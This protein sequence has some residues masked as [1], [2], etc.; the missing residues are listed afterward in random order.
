M[1][2]T[3]FF[4]LFLLF[5]A[6]LPAQPLTGIKTIK[7]GGGDYNS[8]TAAITA[9]NTNGV[10]TGGVVFQVDA[11]FNSTENPPAISATGTAANPVSFIKTGAGTNP[12]LLP[13][14]STATN[15]FG[16]KIDSADYITFDGIDVTISTGNA[17]EFGYWLNGASGNG[18][19]NNTIKN[20]TV[21]LN[22]TNTTTRGINSTVAT[23]VTSA[24]GANSQNKY[25]NVNIT[26]CYNGIILNGNTTFPDL[27]VEVAAVSGTATISS[28][29]GG[30]ILC[31]AVQLSSQSGYIVSG[32]V[33]EN[34]TSSA[35]SQLY[36][37]RQLG[38]PSN[39]SI[40][41]NTVRNISNS[42]SGSIYGISISGGGT[43]QNI[44]NNLIHNLTSTT[45]GAY[46]IEA[47]N[48]NA[49]HFIYENTIH[50]IATNATSNL[51]NAYGI[52]NSG[53]NV[54]L[55]VYRNHIYNIASNG[56]SA[57]LSA[58]LNVSGTNARIYN[59]FIFDIRN[60]S[61]TGT[62]SARGIAL[63]TGTSNFYV[64][65]NTVFLGYT[66]V[67]AANS[68][69]ALFTSAA[70]TADLRNNI[71]VNNVNV[72]A[73]TR[74]VA[75][76]R[77]STT[78]TLFT[79]T[80]DNNLYYAGAP[81]A[82][83][84]VFY[85]GTNADQTLLAY[86]NRM[87]NREWHSV[88][89]LPPFISTT[90]GSHNLHLNTATATQCEQGGRTITTPFA[91]D[92]DFDGNARS[93]SYADLGADEGSFTGNDLTGPY[94]SYTPLSNTTLSA[95][96]TLTVTVT[97]P[98][99]VPT[100]GAGMPVLYW[101]LNN[102]G[103][104]AVTGTNTGSNTFSYTFG[105]G[106]LN[107]DSITYYV[108]AQDMAATPNL[109]AQM[110][111][112]AG[113]YTH[114]PPAAATPP[115]NPSYYLV[116]APV[117][118]IINVGLGE[119]IRTLTGSRGVFDIIKSGILTSD[120]TVYIKNDL[121]EDGTHDLKQW[122]EEGP[123]NYSVTIV[124]FD[125]TLK[126]ISGNVSGNGLIRLNGVK[127][128]TIDGAYNGVPNYFLFR[129]TGTFGPAIMFTGD[130][131]F[132]TIKNS[133]W[134]AA[135]VSSQLGVV[136]FGSVL[137]NGCD[138]NQVL[139]NNIRDRSDGA[140]IPTVGVYS[141]GTTS[142][143]NS[144]NIVS[145]NRIFNFGSFGFAS[146]EGNENWTISNNE[147]FQTVAA[148]QY[149][150]AVNFNSTGTNLISGNNI[151]DL[152]AIGGTG[153]IVAGL[154]LQ[155][156]LNTTVSRNRIYNFPSSDGALAGIFFAGGSGSG[157]TV[158]AI[159]NQ[160]S[161]I[162]LSPSNQVIY[163]IGDE[164]FTGNTLNAYY[165]SVY[166]GGTSTSTINNSWGFRRATINGASNNVVRNNIFFN[167]RTGPG[168]N[169][170]MGDIKHG[171]GSFVATNN[172]YIG[173]GSVT[174][175]SFFE[176]GVGI[177]E[178]F[179]A[180]KPAKRDLSSYAETGA[181]L[182]ADLLFVNKD[183]G[184]MMIRTDT[185]LCW[186]VNGK[187][188]PLAGITDDF[189]GT[190]VRSETIPA[191]S[192]DIGADEFNTTTLPPFLTVT[193]SHTPGGTEQFSFGS[194]T[195]ATINWGTGGILPTLNQVRH[196]TGVWPNDTT[197]NGTISGARF[198]NEWFDMPATGGAGYSYE[199]ILNYDSAMLGK[200]Q[201]ETSMRINKKQTGIP[202]T[203]TAL[204]GSVADVNN[205][206]LTAA[207]QTSFSEFTATD[208]LATLPLQLL[209]F[210]ATKNERDI[211]LNWVVNTETPNTRYEVQRSLNGIQ[212]ETAGTL[213]GSGA[214]QQNHL[215][216][217]T[218]AGVFARFAQTKNFYYRLAIHENGRLTYSP[219]VLVRNDNGTNN[220][221]QAIFPNP[222]RD[223]INISLLL[224]ED[225]TVH[226]KIINAAGQVI[227]RQNHSLAKGIHGLGIYL[228]NQPA[229]MYQ[230]EL[231]KGTERKVFAI[232]KQ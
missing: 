214:V 27:N 103:Y 136:Y 57:S 179:S 210:Y 82:K 145:G 224:E 13:T 209:R 42:S 164:S 216:V 53:A 77:A 28:L 89:E 160:I 120:V 47:S 127:K 84:L 16:F 163:G 71:F 144:N 220:W 215:Y 178:D 225:E 200:I 230:V 171:Q 11:G 21:T 199:L 118:N 66:A 85:D 125:G 211:L 94:I 124:P 152:K 91:V 157:S 36:C 61:G 75:H 19:Q 207:G 176:R 5:C 150:M 12:V 141:I 151:H 113:G 131:S 191:G 213:N 26:N 107:S 149:G 208:A 203:W 73:G 37:I 184:N 109:L 223:K 227:S 170:A 17:V 80:T 165:N 212:F 162:P 48:S 228:H 115:S 132:N 201:Q 198:L 104:T 55:R 76:Y 146:A 79:A 197:N 231:Q 52:T 65:H 32:L 33:I 226:I 143:F 173:T 23:T 129:N 121:V 56:A 90:P 43:T 34:I 219:I 72:S 7:N 20:C 147:F 18:C 175:A 45:G 67:N 167:A 41:N 4:S 182:N 87:V 81:S 161:I 96:R 69:A 232:A 44:Y 2:K 139:N 14:G 192:A 137:V 117:N 63:V 46:G 97:D 187:A 86:Q 29:G 190:G 62:P 108:V 166:I 30:T 194:R 88:S 169:Y 70:A 74:A 148:T 60:P 102:N 111:G 172:L 83:N 10:G 174:P 186:Y 133:T 188:L 195:L 180:W 140:G 153:M 183:T 130:A 123:G 78:L 205:K 185:D 24:A 110:P 128:V 1:L 68:S 105:A 15:D 217:L 138:S 156:S 221:V 229:G 49:T 39:G 158:T 116:V 93:G 59:N 6:T 154:Y 58:G 64:Y 168:P 193:G 135:P 38:T 35:T 155:P 177:A 40:Y 25:L 50:T 159:N 196:Y 122:I 95:P 22:K 106:A 31:T 114:T 101:Q 8:F 99:G 218:D 112:N 204:P 92:N 98:S 3:G 126:T 189:D 142:V 222:F 206:L 181:V 134:E 100:S 202:G 9:L 119:D 51:N 54:N